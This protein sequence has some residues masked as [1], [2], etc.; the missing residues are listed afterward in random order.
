M[1][2]SEP[3]TQSLQDGYFPSCLSHHSTTGTNPLRHIRT[4]SSTACFFVSLT[5]SPQT[6]SS[7]LD[8]PAM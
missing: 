8:M 6:T 3:S 1:T 4:A 2:T 5:V 7:P